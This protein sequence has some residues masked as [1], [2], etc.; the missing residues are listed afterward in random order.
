MND[1]NKQQNKMEWKTDVLGA[2]N[3]AMTKNSTMIDSE[4]IKLEW[5]MFV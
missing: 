3:D 4:I 5:F 2:R 1:M